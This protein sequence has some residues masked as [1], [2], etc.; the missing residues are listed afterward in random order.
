MV[1]VMVVAPPS[2]KTGIAAAALLLVNT[3][4]QPL[5]IEKAAV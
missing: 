4:E 2:H 5:A 1:Q 3:G